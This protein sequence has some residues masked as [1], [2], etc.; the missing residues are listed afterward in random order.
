MKPAGDPKFANEE[1]ESAERHG[2]QINSRPKHGEARE[3]NHDKE[4]AG[5]SD[6]K[7][8]NHTDF[9]PFRSPVRPTSN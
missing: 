5:K 9:V 2:P 7:A 6:V 3:V 1:H 4:N 8:A